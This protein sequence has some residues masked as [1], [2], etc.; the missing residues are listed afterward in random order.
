MQWGPF[1]GARRRRHHLGDGEHPA[2]PR[3]PGSS[4]A[5]RPP[6]ASRRSSA[7]SPSRPRWTRA[8]GARPSRGSRPRRWPGSLAGFAVAGPLFA[9]LGTG[10]RSSLN[11]VLYL[12]SLVDLPLGRRSQPRGVAARRRTRPSG[13]RIDFSRYR[14]ILGRSPRLAPRADLDRDQRGPRACSRR[15]RSSSSSGR[16]TRKFADQLLMGGFE[17]LQISARARRSAG[18]CSSPASSTG[19]TGS[20]P[21]AGRRSSCTASAA[22]RCSSWRR[23]AINHSAALPPV[24]ARC[25]LGGARRSFGLFVLA[26][27]TPAAIGLLADVTEAYP[28][29]SRRDHGPVQRVPRAR[30]DRRRA[31]RRR[32]GERR[33]ASTGSSSPR[34]PA[35]RARASSR[36]SSCAGTSTTSP[37]RRPRPRSTEA[38]RLAECPIGPLDGA[39]IMC[40]TPRHR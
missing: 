5:R 15:R 14:A 10:R 38:D 24:V 32:R 29:R 22:A 12:V 37:V 20:R 39:R 21:C 8:C 35:A 23:S 2:D 33:R 13:S 4:R 16:P 7:S 17:P 19:A 27:A 1:F 36:S 9:V 31:H 30:P 6:R 34:W 26:G 40:N 11:G 25:V 3:A 28:G 18:C